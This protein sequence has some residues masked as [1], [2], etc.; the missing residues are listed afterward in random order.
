MFEVII[1]LERI[2]MLLVC[3]MVGD[4]AL[5]SDFIASTKGKNWYH[6]LVHCVLYIAPFY[7][8][9]GSTWQLMVVFIAHLII[10]PLKARYNKI[11]Y[12]QDQALHY[13]VCLL[14]LI[15]G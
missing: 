8:C 2:F 12:W 10:D 5:Q 7:I 15:R 13:L 9:F 14:Y 4:Y 3:H 1:V 6:M 11:N